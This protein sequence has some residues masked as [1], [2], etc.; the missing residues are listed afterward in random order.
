VPE[1][2]ILDIS[3]T[4]KPKIEALQALK[5]INYSTAMR[6]KHRLSSS[7]R[8]LPLLDV[9]NQSSLDKL[10]E[11]NVRGIAKIAASSTSYSAAEEF[12]YVGVT[13]RIPAKYL[14]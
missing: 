1:P 7:G 12:R 13:Y 10:V 11:E 3:A 14:K 4:M 2:R 6:L 8:N 9:V 5:T